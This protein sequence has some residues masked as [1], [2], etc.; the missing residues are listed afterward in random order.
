MVC[1]LLPVA[2]KHETPSNGNIYKYM[3]YAFRF[4]YSI[5]NIAIFC[6]HKISCCDMRRDPF[7]YLSTYVLGWFVNI[8]ELGV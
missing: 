7:L 1:L 3:A 8:L 2:P 4:M 6:P 5:S